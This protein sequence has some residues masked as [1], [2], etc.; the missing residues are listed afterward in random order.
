MKKYPQFSKRVFGFGQQLTKN[1]GPG[2]P[3][4]LQKQTGQSAS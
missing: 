1:C 4:T 3:N 2:L